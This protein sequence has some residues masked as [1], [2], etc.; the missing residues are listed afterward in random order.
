MVEGEDID[1]DGVSGTI[2]LDDAGD[3]TEGIYEISRYDA[4]GIPVKVGKHSVPWIETKMQDKRNAIEPTHVHS[5]K[6]PYY[7][8]FSPLRIAFALFPEGAAVM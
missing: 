1:Y 5:S 7:K 8:A 6:T 4:A 2:E 3:P